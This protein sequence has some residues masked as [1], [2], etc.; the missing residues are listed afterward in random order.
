[1]GGLIIDVVIAYIIRLVVRFAR[2]LRSGKWP[3]IEARIDSALVGGGWVWNCP[4]ADIAYTYAFGGQTYSSIESIP[5]MFES[6]AKTT[7]D[8]FQA[9]EAVKVRV[10]PSDPQQSILKQSEQPSA[11]R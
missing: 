11:T 1:M 10:N 7:V 3:T 8:R 9:G 6:V 4:T 5:Y 2:T